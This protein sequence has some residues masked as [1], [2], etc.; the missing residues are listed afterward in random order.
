[1]FIV[2]YPYVSIVLKECTLLAFT[3]FHASPKNDLASISTR[4]GNGKIMSVGGCFGSI[5]STN[6]FHLWK[7]LDYPHNAV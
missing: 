2:V 1:M 7:F 3:N 5:F 4:H 6:K